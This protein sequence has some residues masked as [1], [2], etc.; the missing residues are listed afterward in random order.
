MSSKKQKINGRRLEVREVF[1]D[2]D[3]SVESL[4]GKLERGVVVNDDELL[5]LKRQIQKMRKSLQE[6]K[7]K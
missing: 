2:L 7:K 5:S 6:V 1:D 4:L 3:F